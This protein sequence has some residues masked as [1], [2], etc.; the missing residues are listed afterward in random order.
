MIYLMEEKERII[1]MEED[2]RKALVRDL[3]DIPTQTVSAVAMRIRIIMRLMERN[4]DEVPS[5]LEQVEQMALRATEEIRHV[6]FKLRPLALESQG[7][8][9]ALD[10]LAE[11]M[12]KTYKQNVAVRVHPDV[13]LFL[14]ETKQGA[15][16]Y[17]IE[18]AGNN[19]WKYAEAKLIKVTIERKDEELIVRIADN[20]VGFDSEAVDANYDERGSFGM[21]NMRERA[22]LID[23]TLKLKSIPGKG[24]TITVVIPVDA[25]IKS[26]ERT[27]QLRS[28]MPDT[29]LAMN[30]MASLNQMQH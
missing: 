15:L 11:K 10:Q 6:L 4:P 30:A 27:T 28:Q 1:Q 18:E 23:G 2:A 16:F 8:G 3:H 24:T 22:E 5:E 17:L 26:R 9:A 7:L 29:K 14:D 20:G 19:A 13:E 12:Q 21:V 25:T